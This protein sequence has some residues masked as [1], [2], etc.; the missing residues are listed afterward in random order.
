VEIT[1]IGRNSYDTADVVTI[2]IPGFATPVTILADYL[3]G[4]DE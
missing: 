4:D 2:R 3:I 1:R